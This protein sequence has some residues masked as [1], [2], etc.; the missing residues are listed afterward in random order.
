VSDI[1]LLIDIF[2]CKKGFICGREHVAKMRSIDIDKCRPFNR[3]ALPPM[4]VRKFRW[5]SDEVAEAVAAAPAAVK[6]RTPKKKKRSIVE[7]FAVSPQ[8]TVVGGEP[9][10]SDEEM[11][12]S[13]D[14][15][16]GE[17]ERVE[18]VSGGEGLYYADLAALS[19]R[20]GKE[21][22]FQLKKCRSEKSEKFQNKLEKRKLQIKICIARKVY[23]FVRFL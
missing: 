11:E 22:K 2:V 16:T 14:V 13:A 20:E 3:E 23:L 7:L 8:I 4:D 9:I 1:S 6:Q 10:S 21:S 19:K 18:E 17:K 5:W 15:Q 12:G